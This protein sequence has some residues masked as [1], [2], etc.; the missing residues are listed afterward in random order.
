MQTEDV[1]RESPGKKRNLIFIT[2]FYL[3]LSIKMTFSLLPADS[4]VPEIHD[5]MFMANVAGMEEIE[6]GVH[7]VHLSKKIATVSIFF[8]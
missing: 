2:L 8:K 5:D 1:I 4:I 3:S 7:L 6:E